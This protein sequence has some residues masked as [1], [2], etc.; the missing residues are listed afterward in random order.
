MKAVT[1][2]FDVLGLAKTMGC[3]PAPLLMVFLCGRKWWKVIPRLVYLKRAL[4]VVGDAARASGH[5]E[6]AVRSSLPLQHFPLHNL[7]AILSPE[8]KYDF[9]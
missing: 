9:E 2:Q 1:G 7:F 3:V 8:V 5:S 6:S 4:G